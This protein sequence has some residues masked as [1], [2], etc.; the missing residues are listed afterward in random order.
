MAPRP[1]GR[2]RF[3]IT[4]RVRFEPTRY[5]EKVVS[6]WNLAMCAVQSLTVGV[7]WWFSDRATL[8]FHYFGL[9]GQPPQTLP[10]PPFGFGRLRP[11]H[12]LVAKSSMAR[13]EATPT[14]R[15]CSTSRSR[16]A[17]HICRKHVC[18]SRP[19]QNGIVPTPPLRYSTGFKTMVSPKSSSS[20]K[21]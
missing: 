10:N 1:R 18:P 3:Y 16:K 15:P 4:I 6:L 5:W 9:A 7:A 20:P 21:V 17:A 11:H 2:T 14:T 13:Q 12:R 8:V 19:C